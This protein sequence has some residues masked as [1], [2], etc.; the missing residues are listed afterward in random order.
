MTAHGLIN[1]HPASWDGEE[2]HYDDN[3]VIASGEQDRPCKR[4]GLAPAIT[5]AGFA[6]AFFEANP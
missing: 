3:G 2:W 4:C 6:Q 1:G 5:Q